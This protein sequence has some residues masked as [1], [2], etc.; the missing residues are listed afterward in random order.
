MHPRQR[1]EVSM[2]HVFGI[3]SAVVG[4]VG[5]LP[6]A[7]RCVRPDALV[8]VLVLVHTMTWL[9]ER[10]NGTLIPLFPACSEVHFQQRVK[11]FNCEFNY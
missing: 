3:K 10:I 7:I 11:Y 1:R 4:R 8:L 5:Y 2:A 6:V 9:N